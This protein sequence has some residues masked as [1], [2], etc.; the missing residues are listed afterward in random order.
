MARPLSK[1]LVY[2]VTPRRFERILQ[3]IISGVPIKEWIVIQNNLLP[4]RQWIN[5]HRPRSRARSLNCALS[6]E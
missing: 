5:D 4:K 3:G 6:R 2:H 1:D